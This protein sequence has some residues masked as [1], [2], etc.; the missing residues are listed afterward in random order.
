[1]QMGFGDKEEAK[2]ALGENFVSYPA[3]GADE[4]FCYYDRSDDYCSTAFWYQTLPAAPFPPFPSKEE[5]L[6]DLPEESK[7]AKRQDI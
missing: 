6:A 4:E 7:T 3:A 1:M 2:R 5:R